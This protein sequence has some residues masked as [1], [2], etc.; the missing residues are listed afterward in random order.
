[1]NNFEFYNPTKILFGEG[2][3]DNLSSLIPI[4][5]KILLTYGGGSIKTNGIYDA[6]M[7][8][9]KGY[10]ITEFSG[11]SSNPNYDQMMQ[12]VSIAKENQ[13]DFVLAIGGGSVIDAS[14]FICAAMYCDFDPWELLSKQ[15]PPKKSCELGVV[16]TL[17]ATGS[18]M[19]KW[20]V[21]SRDGS[22]LGFGHDNNFPKFS[23]LDPSFTFT[24][25]D[26]Q[27]GN[28]IV[29]AFVHTTEQYLTKIENTPIQNGFCETLLKTLIKEGPKTLAN[30]E[31]YESRS[32]LVWSATMALNGLIGAGKTQDW[33]THMIGHE[34]TALFDIDHAR[35]LAIILPAMLKVQF[36]TKK[37]MLE[38]FAKN[39]WGVE[40]GF[41]AINKT[42]SFFEQMGLATNLSSYNIT[43]DDFSKIIESL[44]KN[45]PF[46]LGENSDIDNAKVLEILE[47]ALD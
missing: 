19:N 2:Q 30:K 14:K 20:S 26:R 9:L 8:K 1:M 37:P 17:P 22:K 16:L 36:E 13:V 4:D 27:V 15:K 29:D 24:L 7:S 34:L 35:T 41:E 40:D 42:K 23:I 43:K 18:E 28:G 38:I 32:N 21:I 12:A 11:I 10:S 33:A 45:I 31:D 47:E 25:S 46:K 5:S 44:N 3:V 39:V 6:V